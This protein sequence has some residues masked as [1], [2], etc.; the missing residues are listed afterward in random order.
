MIRSWKRKGEWLELV[1]SD[2]TDE[3]MGEKVAH[4]LGIPDKMWARLQRE[5][6]VEAAGSR[7]RV[8]L[9]PRQS[10]GFVEE[11]ADIEPLYEDDFC[12]VV[13]KPA[14]M[15]VHPTEPGQG[16]TLANAV[17]WHYASTGQQTAVRHIH[18]LDADTTGPVLYAKN[19][20]AQSKL[21]EAM[22]DKEIGRIYVAVVQGQVTADHGTVNA[23]IGRD[24]HHSGRRR[25]SPTGDQAV[26]HYE[27]VQRLQGA[28][29]VRLELET[30]RTHQ[31]R[32]HM[33]HLGHPLVGDVMYGGPASSSFRRQAL[34]GERLVFPHPFSGETVTVDAPW[35]DDFV[36]LVD[37][38]RFR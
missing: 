26:T 14:G 38:L 25:I 6:G 3:A 20:L 2:L 11:W 7:I 31:I 30:G 36:R 1:Y 5:N 28:T 37:E 22:R 13:N 19:E 23:P 12:L 16:G 18:R 33:S 10:S 21:D 8:K 24:R 35:P 29:L 4:K 15:P 27:T 17:A 32:V 9:F 34:H